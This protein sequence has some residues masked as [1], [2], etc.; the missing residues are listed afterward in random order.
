MKFLEPGLTYMKCDSM[1]VAIEKASEFTKIYWPNDWFNVIKLSKRKGTPYLVHQ[2]AYTDILDFR[3]LKDKTMVNLH[4]AEDGSSLS[5]KSVTCLMFKKVDPR[6]FFKNEYWEDYRAL[7]ISRRSRRKS[8]NVKGMI[9]PE[10]A[11]RSGLPISLPKYRDL[12]EL[13][14]N[15]VIPAEYH[16]FYSSLAYTSLR[17]S[18]AEDDDELQ[19]FTT[20]TVA[21]SKKVS[22]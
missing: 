10:P 16:G 4:V 14:K 7:D 2:L 12:Q 19:L 13:C 22:K 17:T 21:R 20:R 1:H 11:Y 8:I 18:A 6:L 9:Q 5:W 3:G 15:K